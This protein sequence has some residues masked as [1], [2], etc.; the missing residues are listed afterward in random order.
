VTIPIALPMS[1][2]SFSEISTRA[3]LSTSEIVPTT[4]TERV[5]HSLTNSLLR[6]HPTPNHRGEKHCPPCSANDLPRLLHE[7]SIMKD[8]VLLC[9]A[10]RLDVTQNGMKPTPPLMARVVHVSSVGTCTDLSEHGRLPL[11]HDFHLAVSEC[12]HE[13]EP[14][15][16][17]ASKAEYEANLR[18]LRPIYHHTTSGARRHLWLSI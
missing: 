18:V 11:S 10:I 7:Q 2:A 4:T 17:L 14:L 3:M 13:T 12:P 5:E 9:S 15:L 6:Q 16:I 1:L 8:S